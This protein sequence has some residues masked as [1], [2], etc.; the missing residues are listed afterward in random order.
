LLAAPLRATAEAAD[1]GDTEA[2]PFPV[3]LTEVQTGASTGSD[4]FVELY[5]TSDEAIDITGWHV[6]YLNASNSSETTTLLAEI[7]IADGQAVWLPAHSYY[8]LHTATV[9]VAA[10]T[11]GQVYAAKLSSADK[12]VGLFVPDEQTCTL[13]AEDAVAWGASLKGEGAPVQLSSGSSSGDRLLQRY[14]SGAGSYVDTNHNS[15]DFVMTTVSK[16]TAQPGI[17]Q[18]A[19]PGLDNARLLPAEE[20]SPEAG[21]TGPLVPASMD[22]CTV[23]E[24]DDE[25]PPPLSPPDAPPPGTVEQPDTDA[26][27][28]SGPIFPARD[29]GLASPQISELLP[30]PAKP[31]TD[32]ADEFI[33]IY[34]SNSVPFELSGF[35][36]EIGTTTKRRYTFPQGTM[37]P[38]RSF[39]AFFSADTRLAL[40]NTQGQARLLDPFGRLL[41][42][43]DAYSTA[44]DGQ[45]WATV[46]G[47]WQWTTSPTPNAANV[48]KAP[49]A[50]KASAKTAGSKTSGSGSRTAAK[51]ITEANTQNVAATQPSSPLHPGVLALAGVFALLYGAYEYR[52]DVAN[53]LYQFRTNRAARRE[54]R[55]GIKGR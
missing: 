47:K 35:I 21:D 31:Q 24:P 16:D 25:L 2:T 33:E 48:I 22:D 32:A 11:L 13:V 5:N 37:L 27:A 42:Q 43:S 28:A 38:A 17:A 9:P 12:S 26:P 15:H 8:V 52:R 4:E 6:R 46:Q 34:N 30:N 19:T 53:K 14:R 44:K 23:P 18:T 39:K 45:A 10:D 54:A 3:I 41:T 50:K 20:V 51:P 40:S 29:I 55:Q 1:T 36:L 7:A 49:A